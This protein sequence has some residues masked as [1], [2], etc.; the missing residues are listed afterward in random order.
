MQWGGRLADLL[1]TAQITHQKQTLQKPGRWCLLPVHL[2]K[3]HRQN[4]T[5]IKPPGI[6]K[7]LL[8]IQN[9]KVE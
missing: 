9:F 6:F 8:F 1:C 4:K 7:I 2:K 5:K 3:V